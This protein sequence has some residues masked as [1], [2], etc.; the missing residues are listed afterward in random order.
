MIPIN[1]I[2]NSESAIDDVVSCSVG[3][4]ENSFC[5]TLNLEL[6]SQKFWEQCDPN[7]NVGELRIKVVIGNDTYNFLCEERSL[8]VSSNS[9]GFSVWGRSKQ[10][11]LSE[12]YSETISDTE[13]TSHS[14]QADSVHVSDVISYV[15]G[16]SGVSVDWGV[17]DFLIYKDSFS[18]SNKSPIQIISDLA[19]VL[20]AQITPLQDGSIKVES[21]SVV[22]NETIAAR[23]NSLDDI[24]DMAESVDL[25]SGYN[26]VKLYG[27]GD[28]ITEDS[29]VYVDDDNSDISDEFLVGELDDREFG[30]FLSTTI[31]SESTATQ[32][33]GVQKVDVLFY[34]S[35]DIRPIVYMDN[36]SYK[37]TAYGIKSITE[38]V[39][40]I[41]GAGHTSAPYSRNKTELVS[42]S[43]IP[44]KII[45]VTYK[46][47][48]V[49]YELRSPSE[50]GPFHTLFTF[51]D[52]SESSLIIT[53]VVDDS[54]EKWNVC[55]SVIVEKQP[56]TIMRKATVFVYGLVD[57]ISMQNSAGAPVEFKKIDV[58]EKTEE[59]VFVD[60]VANTIYPID[61]IVSCSPD[62][63][64][65]F[66]QGFNNLLKQG[67]VGSVAD[68]SIPVV[69]T[70][71]TAYRVYDSYVPLTWRNAV[72]DVWFEFSACGIKT[73]SFD[74]TSDNLLF[75]GAGSY[76]IAY[77]G[78]WEEKVDITISIKDY[79]SDITVSEATIYIDGRYKGES[80]SEGLL[81]VPAISVGDHTIKIIADGYI[82][83]I[84]DDL[85]NDN[86]TVSAE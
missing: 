4:Q 42:D 9:V 2:I 25:Q 41:W 18:V 5:Y 77:S 1:I 8:S 34:H 13:T 67:Y 50:E 32:P 81:N 36:G 71:R 66:K 7:T 20:G 39:V 10:A 76:A 54:I 61:S 16:G 27:F 75:V 60:G 29:P 53:T 15:V 56:V 83:S 69:I 38:D 49:I 52:K 86:F 46:I 55:A 44:F 80:D 43:S 68:Y 59:V 12:P 23:Y 3:M 58:S 31:D 51:A 70:Y 85:D 57:P 65:S 47:R 14:W 62:V 63:N 72:F 26:A 78:S 73:V 17:N 11:L 45:E 30:S 82:D 74:R 79:V 33:R 28:I 64:P 24:F 35:G 19:N 84:V 21:Y 22:G 37:S 40:F 6:G 48:Y